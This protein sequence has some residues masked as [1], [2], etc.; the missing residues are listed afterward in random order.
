MDAWGERSALHLAPV[1]SGSA[2]DG[3]LED[4]EAGAPVDAGPESGRAGRSVGRG[5]GRVVA[6]QRDAGRPLAVGTGGGQGRSIAQH[7]GGGDRFDHRH[8]ARLHAADPDPVDRVLCLPY[9]PP[10]VVRGAVNIQFGSRTNSIRESPR[11]ERRS[12]S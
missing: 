11:N 4:V 10:Q 12:L 7:V 9:T 5:G 3:V 2:D 8:D 6:G 1:E